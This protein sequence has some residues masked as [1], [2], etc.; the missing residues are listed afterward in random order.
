MI[1]VLAKIPT[2]N[3]GQDEEFRK[4]F[5]WSNQLLKQ[6]PGLV[7]RR[8]AKDRNGNYIAIVE[9][10]SLDTFK[11]LHSSNEHKLIHEKTSLLF[12]GMPQPEFF[13]VVNTI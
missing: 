5:D 10:D 6:T 8:L 2:I 1:I 12:S 4:W 13:E 7:S 9:F 3:Q 11:E